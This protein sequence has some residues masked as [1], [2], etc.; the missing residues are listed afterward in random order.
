MVAEKSGQSVPDVPSLLASAQ[1]IRRFHQILV[2]N[3]LALSHEAAHA[4]LA[5]ESVT[6]TH[7]RLKLLADGKLKALD[8]AVSQAAAN[9]SYIETALKLMAGLAQQ[10]D[11]FGKSTDNRQQQML[12]LWEKSK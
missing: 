2:D 10:L 6:T 3:G 8:N 1:R 7:Q 4:R 9:Q 11:S 5:I 12:L